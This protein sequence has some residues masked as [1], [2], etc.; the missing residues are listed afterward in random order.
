MF[1]KQREYSA[2]EYDFQS[3]PERKHHE[4]FY[5][6]FKLDELQ[7]QFG[8]LKDNYPSA[9]VGAIAFNSHGNAMV[10][11]VPIF[12]DKDEYNVGTGKE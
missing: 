4:M 2:S 11:F 9:R 3:H 8:L 1:E 7:E 10:G 12:I 6:N 5:S